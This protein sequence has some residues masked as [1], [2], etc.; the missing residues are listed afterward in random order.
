MKNKLTALL[1]ILILAAGLVGS[2]ILPD[3]DVSYVERRKLA[4]LDAPTW[5]GFTSGKLASSFEKYAPDQFVL[6]DALRS[7]SSFVRLR[8]LRQSDNGGMFE[9]KGGIYRIESVTEGSPTLLA[10]KISSICREHFSDC[11]IYVSV[12]PDK[13]HFIADSGKPL[14]DQ[15]AAA[16]ELVTAFGAESYKYID[17]FSVLELDDYYLTDPHWRQ[18]A[19]Q[20]VLNTLSSAMDFPAAN[21]SAWQSHS[22]SPFYGSYYG[23]LGLGGRGDELVYLTS[24]ATETAKAD[25]LGESG[26]VYYPSGLSGMDP[27]DVFLRGAQPLVTIEN[28]NARTKKELVIF[29]DSFASSLAPLLSESYSKITLVDIRYMSSALIGEYVS[30]RSCDVLFLYSSSILAD[31]RVLK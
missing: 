20:P 30:A 15:R 28:E 27:Y 3:R 21:I 18:E 14:A 26:E 2:A 17:L 9:Y 6:R 8:I 22:F 19:L 29:R 4:S 25:Y 1:F 31:S 13:T 23:R 11:D 12:I 5:Q 24:G 7:L 16:D 10:E